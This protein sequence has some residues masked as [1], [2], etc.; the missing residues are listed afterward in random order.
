M[1]HVSKVNISTKLTSKLNYSLRARE[2]VCTLYVALEYM[3]VR[4]CR[5]HYL[6]HAC[7]CARTHER[8]RTPRLS[9]ALSLSLSSLSLS[10]SLPRSLSSLSLSPSL[11]SVR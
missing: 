2:V 8:M 3:R 11:S 7:V 4:T 6:P 1:E 10:L 9:L 5:T